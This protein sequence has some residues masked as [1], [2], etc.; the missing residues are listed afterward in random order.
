MASSFTPKVYYP[1]EDSPYRQRSGSVKRK[2]EDQNS[3]AF[4][5]TRNLVQP[6]PQ[7]SADKAKTNEE[8]EVEISKVSSIC[9]KLDNTLAG[10]EIDRNILMVLYDMKDAIRGIVKSQEIILK[11]R[12]Q[13]SPEVTIVSEVCSTP[14]QTAT[15]SQMVSLGNIAKK[16]RQTPASQVANKQTQPQAKPKE[17]SPELEN[18]KEAVKLAERSTL[19]F[20]LDMGRV[21]IMNTETIK[22][23]ATLALTSMAAKLEPGNNTSV[24]CEDTITAIDDVLSLVTN[25]EFYGRKTKTYTNARD[26]RSGLF[27]TIP[28]KYEFEDRDAKYEA[29]TI[30]REKCDAH[31]STPYP[32][33]LREC[34]RQ[35]IEKV[36]TDYPDNQVKVTV[37]T[38]SFSLRVSMRQKVEGTPGRWETFEKNIPL[39]KEALD[40]YSRKFPQGFQM[41]F[42]PPNKE[43]GVK[44]SPEKQRKQSSSSMEADGE[45]GGLSEG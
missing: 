31:V 33:V 44:G 15:N 8:L 37:D 7:V 28:V 24:P 17:V 1:R 25:M 29:E 11:E 2:S 4:V 16:P 18:F 3:Y 43:K 42:L 21:P 40:V 23:K 30:L 35:V 32:A 39:P 45:G 34:I 14:A 13:Q 36:K 41:E 12:K 27:C 9:D 38:S 22:N 10:L 20:N 19:I 5:A 26:K 6:T